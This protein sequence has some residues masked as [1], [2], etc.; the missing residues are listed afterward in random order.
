MAAAMP[1]TVSGMKIQA[2]MRRFGKRNI[3]AGSRYQ[4]D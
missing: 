4:V 1:T 3:K 2:Y